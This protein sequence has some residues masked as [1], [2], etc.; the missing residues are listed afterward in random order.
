MALMRSSLVLFKWKRDDS[1]HPTGIVLT[2]YIVVQ[3]LAVSRAL[4]SNSSES[5]TGV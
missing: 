3:L 1:T 5:Q 4:H 2:A